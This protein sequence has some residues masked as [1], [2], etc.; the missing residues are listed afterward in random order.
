MHDGRRVFSERLTQDQAV[1]SS[2]DFNFEIQLRIDL[3]FVVSGSRD[4]SQQQRHDQ[5]Q[6]VVLGD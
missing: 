5:M 3:G 6:V 4:D 2:N 1:Q